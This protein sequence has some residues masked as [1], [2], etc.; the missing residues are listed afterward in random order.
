MRKNSTPATDDQRLPALASPPCRDTGIRDEEDDGE[1]DHLANDHPWSSD[2]R[3]D[4]DLISQQRDLPKACDLAV[5]K[6]RP[7]QDKGQ[8]V[9]RAQDAQGACEPDPPGPEMDSD[10]PDERDQPEQYRD[11]AP[12]D[13]REELCGRLSPHQRQ[14]TER[15][16]R[17]RER[18][19]G[20]EQMGPGGAV[21]VPHQPVNRSE[22]EAG[23]R[24]HRPNDGDRIHE[25]PILSQS[26]QVG[27]RRRWLPRIPADSGPC[28][29]CIA[30]A[31][32]TDYCSGRCGGQSLAAETVP[33]A[34]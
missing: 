28:R 7:Q 20:E 27:D 30:G 33:P 32:S 16:R 13:A 19:R 31:L 12:L 23:R 17:S 26:P 18:R 29:N 5:E 10:E 15:E 22:G 34:V 4:R 21:L 11:M 24:D 6:S 9:K 14:F 8:E 25:V 2:H 1:V 3:E